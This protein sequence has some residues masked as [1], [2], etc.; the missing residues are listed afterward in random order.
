MKLKHFIAVVFLMT[1][2]FAAEN[3]LAQ[4][5]TSPNDFGLLQ[6]SPQLAERKTL[7]LLV[8]PASIRMY[9]LPRA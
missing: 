6:P 8:M 4:C 2:Q 3:T 1:L 5:L 7:P 9:M